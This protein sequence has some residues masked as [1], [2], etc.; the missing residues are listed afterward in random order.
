MTP[1]KA[2]AGTVP[3]APEEQKSGAQRKQPMGRVGRIF[4]SVAGSRRM[5]SR[6]R[7]GPSRMQLAFIRRRQSGIASQS[8]GASRSYSGRTSNRK[9]R[10][11]KLLSVAFAIALVTSTSSVFAKGSG[12]RTYYGGSSHSSSHGESYQGGQ[13]ALT[14][15]ASTRIA[16]LTTDT[17]NTN[18]SGRAYWNSYS[19]SSASS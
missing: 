12:G 15:V 16:A 7:I 19:S 3:K 1:P 6:T 8:K 4:G 9:Q 17:A 2:Q 11:R 18:R 13:G 5:Q 14:V 10:M